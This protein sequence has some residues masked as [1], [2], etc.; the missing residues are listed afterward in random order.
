MSTIIEN[1]NIDPGMLALFLAAAFLGPAVA[2]WF[3][4]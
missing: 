4:G 2:S 3:E 1:A